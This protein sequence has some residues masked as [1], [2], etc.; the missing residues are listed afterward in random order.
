MAS[1]RAL[2]WARCETKTES[3]SFRDDPGSSSL[4]DDIPSSDLAGLMRPSQAMPAHSSFAKPARE[5]NRLHYLVL[6][7]DE[8]ATSVSSIKRSSVQRVKKH[9]FNHTAHAPSD[10]PRPPPRTSWG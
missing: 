8:L 1:H 10:H 3:S 5:P 6:P 9:K 7:S 2:G 4:K